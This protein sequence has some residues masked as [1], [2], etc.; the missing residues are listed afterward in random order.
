VIRVYMNGFH[1]GD[2]IWSVDHGSIDT[3]SK[4]RN[5]LIVGVTGTTRVNLDADNK[6]EPKAWIEIQDA[7]VQIA[8]GI[9]IVR[10][11]R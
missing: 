8:N 5:V 4:V 10:G 3:E 6:R 1:E 11:D 9:A 2:L 7:R